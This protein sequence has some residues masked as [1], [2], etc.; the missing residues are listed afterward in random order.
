MKRTPGG[1]RQARDDVIAA[2]LEARHVPETDDRIGDEL[3]RLMNAYERPIYNFLLVLLRDADVAQ[4]CAQDTFLRAYENLR[5]GKPVNAPWL[6]TVA[7]NRAMDEFRRTRRL[8]PGDSLDEVPVYQATDRALAVQAVLEQL[9]PQDREVL[10]L[11][12]VAGFKTDEIGAMLGARGSAI[13]QRLSR[14][15]ERFRVLYG[16]ET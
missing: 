14:A 16:A 11:F 5:K 6:Y 9:S 4:D 13:R 15:R 1:E 12:D 2:S 3:I 8:E 7:R 10:Y